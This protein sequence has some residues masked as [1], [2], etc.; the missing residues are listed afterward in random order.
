MQYKNVIFRQLPD[1]RWSFSFDLIRHTV[2]RTLFN[3][4]S[5]CQNVTI[6]DG[7]IRLF[8]ALNQPQNLVYL[9]AVPR[10]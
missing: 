10:S 9:A 5:L 6:R 7:E 1:A 3:I 4:V 2:K 8:C